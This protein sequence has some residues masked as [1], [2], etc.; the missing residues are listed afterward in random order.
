MERRNFTGTSH[1]S[2]APCQAAVGIRRGPLGC[3][4]LAIVMGC[5]DS[6]DT[7]LLL[8]QYTAARDLSLRGLELCKSLEP[9]TYAAVALEDPLVLMLG[10][11]AVALLYLGHLDQ[12]HEQVEAARAE[13]LRLVQPVTLG[14]ALFFNIRFHLAIHAHD[15]ALQLL[16]ELLCRIEQYGIYLFEPS[17]NIF[18]G[19]C[20]AAL[21]ES[22]IGVEL[23]KGG[24]AAHRASGVKMNLPTHLTSLA[25]A[26]GRAG[27]SKRGLRL[28]VKAEEYAE[29]SGERV[30]EA[31]IHLRSRRFAI[32]SSRRGWR[33][34]VLSAR[35]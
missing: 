31:E 35:D 3:A 1:V 7:S 16:D 9:S 10:N 15:A 17:A 20:L 6:G 18:R 2:S 27:Q 29:E 11:L 19:Q 30:D 32:R 5:Q 28:L 26:Y 25:Y 33:G 21:G 12:A 24:L 23:I 4:S 8:G 22:Q 13:A 34:G 14:W